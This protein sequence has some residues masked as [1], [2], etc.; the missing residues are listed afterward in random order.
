MTRTRTHGHGLM[1]LAGVIMVLVTV[2]RAPAQCPKYRVV[3]LGALP[4]DTRSESWAIND[5]GQVVGQANTGPGVFHAFFWDNAGCMGNCMHDLGT[6]TGGPTSIAYDINNN[7]EIV[8]E[9]YTVIDSNTVQRATYWGSHLSSPG[10]LGTIGQG[11]PGSESSVAWA[12]NSFSLI[13]GESTTDIDCEEDPLSEVLRAFQKFPSGSMAALPAPIGGFTRPNRN[14]AAY[15][16]NDQTPPPAGLFPL[17][18]GYA[19]PCGASDPFCGPLNSSDSM[20]WTSLVFDLQEPTGFGDGTGAVRDVNNLDHLVGWGRQQGGPGGQ[21]PCHDRALFWAS[22]VSTPANLHD[23]PFPDTSEIPDAE[24]TR[25]EALNE[26]NQ[27]VGQNVTTVHAY[28]WTFND[29]WTVVDLNNE[30]NACA[31]GQGWVLQEGRDINESGWIVGKGGHGG[32]TRAFLLIPIATCLWDIAPPDEPGACDPPGQVGSPD[33]L[34]LLQA[35]GACNPPNGICL[36]DFDCDG[37]VGTTDFLDLLAHWGCCDTVCPTGGEG[38]GQVGGSGSSAI[39]VLQ[40]IMT[41]GF[42]SME[43]FGLWMDSA[44]YSEAAAVIETLKALLLP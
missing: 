18:G 13:T 28:L 37:T 12:I 31:A 7:E 44:T 14:S 15:A 22:I 10:N 19:S 42:A 40:A 16:V 23:A 5:L 3:D 38:A 17:F 41:L 32:A 24:E 34:A 35:W 30:I 26:L 6:L 11:P 2:P 20:A 21:P 8:G 1:L 9:S 43:E 4:G 25:G 27:V 39:D 29:S 33:F 36:A